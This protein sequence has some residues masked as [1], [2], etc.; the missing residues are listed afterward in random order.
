[1]K[2]G[3]CEEASATFQASQSEYPLVNKERVSQHLASSKQCAKMIEEAKKFTVKKSYNEA[4]RLLDS[5][6]EIASNAIDLRIDLCRLLL[7]TQQWER[8]QQVSGVILRSRPDHSEVLYMRG[9]VY[10]M[11]GDR[12]TAQSHFKRVVS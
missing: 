10:V 12:E 11:L 1:M 4:I 6:L 2:L 5:T 8:L 9:W 3:L 7:E